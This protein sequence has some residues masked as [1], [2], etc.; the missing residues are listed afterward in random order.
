MTKIR[1]PLKHIKDNIYMRD[2]QKYY[3][4]GIY[5]FTQNELKKALRRD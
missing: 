2:K 3:K 5:F 1:V 4:V